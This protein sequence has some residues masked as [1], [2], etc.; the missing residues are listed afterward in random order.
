MESEIKLA[1]DAASA[2]QIKKS[3]VLR[4]DGASKP[5]EQEHVDRYF[6][7]AAFD[8][9]QHG[10]AL[11]VRSSGGRH[12]QTLKGGGDALAGLHRRTELESEIA[13][14]TPDQAV[15]HEQLRQALPDLARHL[16]GQG[17]ALDTVFVNRSKRTS[18]MLALADGT[19]VECAFDSGELRRGDKSAP[20]RELELEIKEGDPARLYELARQVHA[21]TPVRIEHASKA[22]RGYQLAGAVAPQAVK[23]AKVR[24]KRKASMAQALAAILA[25]CLQQMQANERGVLA[26][27]VEGLH[28]MRVGLRRLRAAL[29]MVDRMVQLP[30]LLRDDIEWLAGELG[31]ARNWDVFIES[32]L[33]G[34]PLPD[35]HQGAMERVRVAAREEAQRHHGKVRSAVSS[36]RYTGLLLGLGAWLAGKGW[37]QDGL[38]AE[39]L[40]RKVSKAAPQLVQH[41]SARVRKRARGHD[42]GRPECLHKVR[43]AA[44]KERY[45][46]EFFDAL[47]HGK[48]AARRH[49]LLAGMQDELGL[50]NDSFVARGLVEQLRA[51][52]PQEPALLGFIDGVL[53]ARAAQALPLA[54]KHVKGRLRGRAGF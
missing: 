29:A 5:Q 44:K 3:P 19:R 24:V 17:L 15:L 8:L 12:V 2:S 18:W 22:E 14:E 41:A 11:R 35:E 43:I 38:D 54:R 28:Q 53:A 32:V 13:S 48:K 1:V 36:A 42:L 27:D 6:D 4:T 46:R 33:P 40:A 47:D 34:L 9:W 49:D 39:A 45:A 16:D 50:I 10:F 20:V 31:D 23:A 7:S 30:Q 25:N 37:E 51:R 26:G 21:A 52:L